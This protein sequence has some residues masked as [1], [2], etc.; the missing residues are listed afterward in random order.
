M[1]S[2]EGPLPFPRD[3][4]SWLIAAVLFALLMLFY[5]GALYG[6]L[7]DA[8]RAGFRYSRDRK[9]TI[10]EERE[11]IRVALPRYLSGMTERKLFVSV[12]NPASAVE[13]ITVTLIPQLSIG[14]ESP[15]EYYVFLTSSGGDSNTS[16]NGL[17]T[18]ENIPPGATIAREAIL[19]EMGPREANRTFVFSLDI[20]RP[21]GARET[22]EFPDVA[23]VT[24]DPV[25]TLLQNLVAFVLLPP[26]ANGFIPLM[27]LFCVYLFNLPEAMRYFLPRREDSPN[28]TENPGIQP[29]PPSAAATEPRQEDS[30]GGRK[31]SKWW[32]LAWLL[33]MFLLAL[34]FLFWLT[35]LAV[36][37]LNGASLMSP[38][39][40]AVLW[41]GVAIAVWAFDHTKIQQRRPKPV[42]ANTA[43]RA[44]SLAVAVSGGGQFHFPRA[45]GDNRPSVAINA[46]VLDVKLTEEARL[47]FTHPPCPPPPPGGGGLAAENGGN[48]EAEAVPVLVPVDDPPPKRPRKAAKP[49]TKQTTPPPGSGP[50]E[51]L[52]ESTPA[53]A[54]P[55]QL[56]PAGV[57]TESVS[58]AAL[59]ESLPTANPPTASAVTTTTPTPPPAAKPSPLTDAQLP[60][61][62]RN[63]E[64]GAALAR[65]RPAKPAPAPAP[66]AESAPE[67]SPPDDDTAQPHVVDQSGAIFQPPPTI[68]LPKPESGAELEEKLKV[69][70]AVRVVLDDTPPPPPEPPADPPTV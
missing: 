7:E 11:I 42:E 40:L 31:G 33:V 15:S 52:V 36:A 46:A 45:E 64:T 26:W 43:M 19:R 27:A 34:S 53:G 51:A 37:I 55:L 22:L 3:R 4:F 23:T 61:F 25:R 58:P 13:P 62:L 14:T 35:K 69:E 9:S 59:A 67:P 18:F 1:I 65:R 68:V 44:E 39:G 70:E 60:S 24:I 5:Y 32:F 30:P 48:G 12:T 47:N 28:G 56:P 8:Y 6:P 57:V 29:A 54:A 10:D 50:A 49:K 63:A 2:A 20:I 41:L 16:R 21:N 17:L 66:P 38:I